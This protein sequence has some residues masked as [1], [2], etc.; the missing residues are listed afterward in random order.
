MDNRIVTRR[1][2]IAFILLVSL[3]SFFFGISTAKAAD[4]LDVRFIIDSSASMKSADPDNIRVRSLQKL[5]KNLPNDARSGVW[6]Y[7]KYVNML[8]PLGTSDAKWKKQAVYNLDKMNAYGNSSNLSSA[9]EAAL[10]GWQQKGGYKKYIVV[11]TNSKNMEERAVLLNKTL[12][13]LKNAGIKLE[14][15]SLSSSKELD[16]RLLKLLAMQTKGKWYQVSDIKYLDKVMN[17][18]YKQVGKKQ[19][20]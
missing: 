12:P 7:G 1:V 2:G 10:H 15:I 8:V 20:V 5:I 19:V 9:I 16:H 6:T 11:V 4:K 14:T 18:V 17:H 3:I 13:K